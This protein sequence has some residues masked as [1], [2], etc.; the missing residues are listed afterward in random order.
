MAR[1]TFGNDDILRAKL[2]PPGKYK[3]RVKTFEEQAAGTDGSA[4]Y[5]Y[6]LEI[7]AE[8]PFK[9]VQI[10]YQISEKALGMGIE[11]L[12][13]VGIEIKPGVAVNL[14]DA[15]KGNKEFEGIVQRGEY[16]GRG[17][18]QVVGFAKLKVA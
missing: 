10:R 14:E 1:V 8:G 3:M 17:N 4:L 7:T 9:G 18:N 15:G 12:E 11:F 6:M 2:V 13:A 16:N 5:V